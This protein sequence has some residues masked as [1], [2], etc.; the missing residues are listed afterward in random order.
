MPADHDLE[1][2]VKSR[3][4]RAGMGDRRTHDHDDRGER[5]DAEVGIYR[6]E[7]GKRRDGH[8]E[9]N[10]KRNFIY[11]R[12][13]DRD[14]TGVNR[15]TERTYQIFDRCLQGP[16]TLICV[17]TTAVNTAHRPPRGMFNDLQEQNLTRRRLSLSSTAAIAA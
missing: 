10:Q 15:S 6:C 16:P 12:N 8:R 9:R 11:R 3:N 13:K 7:K 5:R 2:A 1:H 14:H 17:T 4:N